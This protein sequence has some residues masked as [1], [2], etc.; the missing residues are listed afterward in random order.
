[1]QGTLEHVGDLFVLMRV[2]RYLISLLEIDV[3]DHHALARDQ[4]PRDG[5]LH[6]LFGYF[7][8]EIVLCARRVVGAHCFDGIHGD[9]S[10]SEKPCSENLS[11]TSRRSADR[12]PPRG[13]LSRSRAR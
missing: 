9:S 2:L 10:F 13:H 1:M 12:A 6:G 11:E 5:A 3:R 4:A 7:L 8:P